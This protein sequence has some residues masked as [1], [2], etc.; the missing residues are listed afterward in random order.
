MNEH[1]LYHNHDVRTGINKPDIVKI[2]E[3]LKSLYK[4]WDTPIVT[5]IKNK[6]HN[7]FRILIATI[8]SQRT[9]DNVTAEASER[10]FK[11]AGTPSVMN[12]LS[13]KQFEKAIYPV[14]FY[15]TKAKRIKSIVY[16][17]VNKYNGTVPD[18]VEELIK[19][20]GVGRKTANLV[21][22]LGYN[23][24]GICVDTH[25]HRISNRFGF[26]KTKT[27]Y[28]TEMA[29]RKTLP[30]KYWIIY[31]D[32]LVSLGQAI[33]RPVS[34]KCSICPVGTYCQRIGVKRSR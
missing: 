25:V 32:L 15:K 18:T 21:I 3:C 11:L 9:K 29:L 17:I 16:I 2:I 4:Q 30:V 28:N 8:L 10:L 33:C 26:V 23:K 34:P 27:P 1:K 13:V 24:L 5:K 12:R 7:P 20:K 31:N 14:G 22:T 6:S 19:L